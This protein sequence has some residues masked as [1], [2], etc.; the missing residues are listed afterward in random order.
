MKERWPIPEQFK[1]GLMEVLIKIA[2][3]KNST[4]RDRIQAIKA[5]LAADSANVETERLAL[6]QQA[7]QFELDQGR[8]RVAAILAGIRAKRGVSADDGSGTISHSATNDESDE[9]PSRGD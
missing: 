6:E 9:Q 3:D 2:A 1:Q 4:N 5:L 7:A 8:D